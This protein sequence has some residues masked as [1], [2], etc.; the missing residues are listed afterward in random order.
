MS[1]INKKSLVSFILAFFP[2]APLL[3]TVHAKK[4]T[5]CC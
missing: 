3:K 5:P 4:P 2:T 1:Q